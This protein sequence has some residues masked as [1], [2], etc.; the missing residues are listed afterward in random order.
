MTGSST[1]EQEY[2]SPEYNDMPW[3]WTEYSLG[4]KSQWIENDI[5]TLKIFAIKDGRKF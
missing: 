3:P 4:F 2:H 1:F 5:L